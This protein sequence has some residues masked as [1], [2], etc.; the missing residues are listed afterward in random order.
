MRHDEGKSRKW[1]KTLRPDTLRPSSVRGSLAGSRYSSMLSI[2]SM[3]NLNRSKSMSNF[4]LN[5]E[6][7]GAGDIFK[8][9]FAIC[10]SESDGV[11]LLWLPYN[12]FSDL[13]RNNCHESSC[14][15]VLF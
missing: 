14:M 4:A 8:D 12:R 6:D 1:R 15:M 9:D 11:K 7:G 13:C 3:E 10:D 5:E 2:S